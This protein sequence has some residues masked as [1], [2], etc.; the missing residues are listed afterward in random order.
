ML[1]YKGLR[2]FS[3]QLFWCIFGVMSNLLQ[4]FFYIDE[5]MIP[6]VLGV[7]AEI[8]GTGKLRTKKKVTTRK[9][10]IS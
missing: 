7:F 6:K 8:N 5:K 3:D 2:G 9:V 4:S 1:H 10:N